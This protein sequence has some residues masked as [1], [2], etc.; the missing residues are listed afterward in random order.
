MLKSNFYINN[1]VL[2]QASAIIFI[3]SV[4]HVLVYQQGSASLY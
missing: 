3:M 2:P 4:F 1:G